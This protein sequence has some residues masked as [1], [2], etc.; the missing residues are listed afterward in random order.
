MRGLRDGN[1][2]QPGWVAEGLGL[3]SGSGLGWGAR[4]VQPGSVAEGAGLVSGSGFGWTRE[5]VQPSGWVAEVGLAGWERGQVGVA[6]G[7]LL[8]ER[9][10]A[11]LATVADR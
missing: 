4:L 5:L 9:E 7:V 10:S 11:A 6:R 1:G 2:V 8:G 3:V